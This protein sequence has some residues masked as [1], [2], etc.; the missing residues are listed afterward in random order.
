MADWR[1]PSEHIVSLDV[2]TMQQNGQTLTT[3]SKQFLLVPHS[4]PHLR[5]PSTLPH[6]TIETTEKAS[7]SPRSP[8]RL[9]GQ[10]HPCSF[11]GCILLESMISR[12]DRVSVVR[13]ESEGVTEE[14]QQ[15]WSRLGE[16]IIPCRHP[17]QVTCSRQRQQPPRLRH[18]RRVRSGA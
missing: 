1:P 11:K 14:N 18:A 3:T 9:G 5:S 6:P 10:T 16:S 4:A 13:M 7:P 17:D 8:V 2:V 15:L 12:D